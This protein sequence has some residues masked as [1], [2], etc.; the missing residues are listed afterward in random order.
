M[1]EIWSRLDASGRQELALMCLAGL[2][3]GAGLAKLQPI[4]H[5]LSRWMTF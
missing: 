1:F 5:W 4:L 2:L 3:V